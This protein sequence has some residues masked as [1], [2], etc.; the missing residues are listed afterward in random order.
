MFV[1][2]VGQNE[3]SEIQGYP[4][5]AFPLGMVHAKVGLQLLARWKLKCA[6][7]F[8]WTD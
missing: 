7:I 6:A 1:A 4:S 8:S 5:G 3:D 2:G